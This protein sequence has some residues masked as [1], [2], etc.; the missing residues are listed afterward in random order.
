[1]PKSNI[2]FI[3][4]QNKSVIVHVCFVLFIVC[5]HICVCECLLQNNNHKTKHNNHI[6][7]GSAF[8]PGTSGLPYYCA[9]IC[10]RSWCTW[11]GSSVDSKP[12]KKRKKKGCR[13]SLTAGGRSYKYARREQQTATQRSFNLIYTA[14]GRGH[15]SSG[16]LTS[17]VDRVATVTPKL[18]TLS[19]RRKGTGQTWTWWCVGLSRAVAAH[20]THN[21]PSRGTNEN[22]QWLPTTISI[23]CEEPRCACSASREKKT[24]AAP[25]W[26]GRYTWLATLS[27]F[28]LW[29]GYVRVMTNQ[30]KTRKWEAWHRRAIRPSFSTVC[31]VYIVCNLCT[32]S[33]IWDNT[34]HA[35]FGPAPHGDRRT[36]QRWR[37]AHE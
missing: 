22:I 12:N 11:R 14:R 5:L 9:S 36:W 25:R 8:E 13:E 35:K 23:K 27:M 10:V 30:S 20:R 1:M 21:T 15:S 34:N 6:N 18:P 3:P 31:R 26:K 29:V 16:N 37:G 19:P 4:I 32:I 24:G 2:K 7:C 28:A 17:T 33:N